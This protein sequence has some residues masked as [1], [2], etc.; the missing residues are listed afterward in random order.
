MEI[1]K[2]STS[3][4]KLYFDLIVECL[5]TLVHP[6]TAYTY[7]FDLIFFLLFFNHSWLLSFLTL[8]LCKLKEK[9]S[10]GRSLS[11]SPVILT[12]TI[13]SSGFSQGLNMFPFN[14]LLPVNQ[15]ELYTTAL[16]DW[17]RHDER[18]SRHLTKS[19]YIII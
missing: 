14:V 15:V 10:R 13:S 3:A 9:N 7:I 2:L 19:I 1:I 17:G 4:S 6:I 5:S 18:S 16:Y 8:W 12:N 11:L